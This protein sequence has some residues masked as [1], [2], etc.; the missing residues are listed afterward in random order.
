MERIGAPDCR[1]A[2]NTSI[3]HSAFEFFA[4]QEAVCD[5]DRSKIVGHCDVVGIIEAVTYRPAV[6][7]LRQSG[8]AQALGKAQ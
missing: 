8:L 5:F 4:I 7:S 6:G 2:N 1:R 3:P